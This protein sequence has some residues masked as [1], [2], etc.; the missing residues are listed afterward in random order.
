MDPETELARRAAGGDAA[1]FTRLV[2]RHAAPVRRF[3]RRL[4]PQDGADD[5]AQEVFVKAWRM[6]AAW[7]EDGPYGAWLMRIAWTSFVSFYRANRRHGGGDA[8]AAD[9]PSG[10]RDADAALD[11]AR[12]MAGLEP[13][14]RAAAQLCFAEGYSHGEAAHILQLPLGTL[15]NVVARARSQLAAA[16]ETNHDA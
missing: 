6:R 8:P 2:R 9:E 12:A 15:K 7:R 3:L 4:L 10:Y 11:M 1:A 13:R 5:V 16:L 14:E